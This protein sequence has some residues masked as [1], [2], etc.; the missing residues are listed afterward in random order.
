MSRST[1]GA[2]S[3]RMAS[4]GR[5]QT[6]NATSAAIRSTGT[7]AK[8]RLLTAATL[9]ARFDRPEQAHPPQLGELALVR[10]EHELARVAERRL[11]DRALPLAEH[12]GVGF[13]RRRQRRAGLEHVEEHAVKVEAVDQI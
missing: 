3:F 12:Q 1:G 7:S 9:R 8:R 11:E 5:H 2:P 10:V 13:L 6:M 4:A